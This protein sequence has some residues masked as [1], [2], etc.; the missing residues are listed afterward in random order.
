VQADEAAFRKTQESE[1]AKLAQIRKVQENVDRTREQNA[2]RKMDKIQSR[3]WDSG[4]PTSDLKRR[5]EKSESVR[6]VITGV[7]EKVS[8][9]TEPGSP[10]RDVSGRS[11]FRGVSQRSRGKEKASGSGVAEGFATKPSSSSNPRDDVEPC[12]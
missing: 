9:V 7:S 12:T 6:D 2:K 5:T 10:S 4:K 3:E 1:R 11:S 8:S